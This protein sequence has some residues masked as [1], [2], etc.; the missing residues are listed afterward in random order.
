MQFKTSIGT[1]AF[2]LFICCFTNIVSAQ[3]LEG[4]SD[5]FYITTE[6]ENEIFQVCGL[7]PG[8]NYDVFFNGDAVNSNS[9]QRLA[10][11][12][13]SSCSS[14][15]TPFI[16]EGKV[17]VVCTDCPLLAVANNSFMDSPIT[18][19]V[20]PDADDLINNVLFGNN[21]LEVTNAQAIGV[22]FSM[23]QYAG[24][25][26]IF[27]MSD[28]IVL[29]TGDINT[30]PFASDFLASTT[31][32]GFGFDNDLA[33]LVGANV[34]DAVS[35]EFDLVVPNDTLLEF[36]YTFA[37]EEYCE[38]STSNFND[39]FGFFVSGPGIAGPFT[40]GAVNI[41]V[42][43]DNSPTMVNGVNQFVNT[44]LFVA[45]GFDCPPP[46]FAPNELAFDGFTLSFIASINLVGGET[47]HFRLAIG[48]TSD[49]LLDSAVFIEAATQSNYTVEY[50]FQ[51]E[52]NTIYEDCSQTVEVIISRG[53]NYPFDEDLIVPV[54]LDASS[55]A[56]EG[57]DFSS[58]PNPIT[59]PAGINSQSFIITAF[60]D[61]LE[62]GL[63]TILL[64][65]GE[66]SLPH[67]I[68]ISDVN[69]L[70]NTG[71]VNNNCNSNTYEFFGVTAG[72]VPPY[73][74]A[75]TVDNGSISG[76]NVTITADA[77]LILTSTD[78]CG[79]T[80]VFPFP[81]TYNPDEG[82]PLMASISSFHE[83]E[84]GF[85]FLTG[86][87][88][89]GIPPYSYEWSTGAIGQNTEV[90][91]EPGG[92]LTIL[93][94]VTDDCGNMGEEIIV[95]EG[96][97]NIVI[98]GFTQ[99]SMEECDS[100]VVTVNYDSGG[101]EVEILWSNGET[102]ETAFDLHSGANSVTITNEFGCSAFGTVNVFHATGFQLAGTTTDTSGE[103]ANDGTISVETIGGMPPFTFVWD[104]GLIGQNITGLA[105]GIYTVIVTD[106]NGCTQTASY[107][108]D[109]FI[110]CSL[111]GDVL[112][113]DVSCN[114]NNDGNATVIVT[115]GL[116]PYTYQWSNGET[117]PTIS[118]LAAGTYILT[119]TDAETC[120]DVF[121][122]VINENPPFNLEIM[123][124]DT[125]LCEGGEVTL[126]LSNEYDSYLWSNGS[127]EAEITVDATGIY[128]VIVT[129]ENGCSAIAESSV[130]IFNGAD[131]YTVT[132][133]TDVMI[134][135]TISYTAETTTAVGDQLY[136]YV[137]AGGEII[138]A[139]NEASVTVMWTE[140]GSFNLA[141]GIVS[142]AG[143]FPD[144]LAIV[145]NVGDVLNAVDATDLSDDIQLFPN[146]V[147]DI[148]TIKTEKNIQQIRL[149][150][151]AGRVL[152]TYANESRLDL[153]VL[154]AGIYFVEMETTEGLWTEK[155]VKL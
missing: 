20:N 19:F 28:G 135:E 67:L 107:V 89:G 100:T 63:E 144:G 139:N 140:T 54:N 117:T 35:I 82:E 88:T 49:S 132:G 33:N 51:T 95:L 45:N 47:Y 143:C 46:Y 73:D 121:F 138:G 136:W 86:E 93:L 146:P 134:G 91:V 57:V 5:R 72:G 60:S 6:S 24:A 128:T 79:T 64:N 116:A 44:E 27:G 65:L 55:T 29:S 150:D 85:H 96:E 8:K 39:V 41:A 17:S 2:L 66:C 122:V 106:A 71:T 30:I 23:G 62:E 90:F 59:I 84:I 148:L 83:C 155:V 9:A 74:E 13:T 36:V 123:P 4:N 3:V 127:T 52:D 1:L 113:T 133:A 56:I 154:P 118:N 145:V 97:S 87:A 48:D 126:S 16:G 58:L 34:N 11:E 50:V 15:P 14:F 40:N 141:L 105:P 38:F 43:P 124:Q 129:D 120:T 99:T 31:T 101:Q 18:T 76:D 32:G 137:P 22:P 92:I 119:V 115:S 68:S 42:L 7:V 37:S 103:G 152:R 114:G 153:G 61:D 10:I 104:N 125:V 110:A 142:A 25:E 111:S 130:F 80:A 131:A 12:A 69:P 78:A 81:L 77:T 94:T 147:S 109:P 98:T 112:V 21:C 75:W 149:I 108:I 53:T 102:G 26:D 70:V 151:L